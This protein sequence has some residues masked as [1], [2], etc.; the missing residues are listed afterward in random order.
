MPGFAGNDS[1]VMADDVVS[2][3]QRARMLSS[4]YVVIRQR[5][6]RDRQDSEPMLG[7]RDDNDGN[8][9]RCGGE[10]ESDR[11]DIVLGRL[12]S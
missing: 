11:I 10:F 2:V 1:V 5:P 12:S 6:K 9:K 3:Y 4:L 7:F 8:W